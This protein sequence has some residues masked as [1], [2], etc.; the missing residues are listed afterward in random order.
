MNVKVNESCVAC[1]ACENM[2][3]DVFHVEE[4]AEVNSC[5]ISENEDCVKE[6]AAACPVD[7]IEIE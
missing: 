7:A 6:A 3:S 2:C 4:K 1:G 5:C